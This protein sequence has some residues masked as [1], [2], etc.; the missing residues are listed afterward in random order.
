MHERTRFRLHSHD[1][2]YG[3]GSGQQ[4]VTSFPNVDDANSYWVCISLQLCMKQNLVKSTDPRILL[5]LEVWN[6]QLALGFFSRT[7]ITWL[8]LSDFP[9]LVLEVQV[10]YNLRDITCSVIIILG[11]S[12]GFTFLSNFQEHAVNLEQKDHKCVNLVLLNYFPFPSFYHAFTHSGNSILFLA[13]GSW[14][15]MGIGTMNLS[16]TYLHV[17]EQSVWDVLSHKNKLIK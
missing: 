14:W 11:I 5:A 16:R 8:L 3:S 15:F 17:C 7:A 2:P 12:L 4:S 1:V 10:A 9:V 6:D 13:V